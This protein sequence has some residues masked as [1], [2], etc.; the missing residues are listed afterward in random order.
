MKT[1]NI[2]NPEFSLQTTHSTISI[3]QMIEKKIV[4]LQNIITK[5]LLSI[6]KYKNFDIIGANE[7]NTCV[8]TLENIFATLNDMLYPIQNNQAFDNEQH[9]NKLQEV[10]IELSGLFK[11]FGTDNIEDLITI[12]FGSEFVKIFLKNKEIYDKYVLMKRYV[13]PIGYKAIL[14]KD[15]QKKK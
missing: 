12:C 1:N 14:W 13:H 8:Q 6:Q 11:T 15:G 5:T 2:E 9:I 3:S 4:Y 7:Y 10:T